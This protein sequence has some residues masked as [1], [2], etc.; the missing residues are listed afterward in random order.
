MALVGDTRLLLLLLVRDEQVV[1][2]ED[3]V[4]VLTLLLQR[5]VS[6]MEPNRPVVG[7][8]VALGNPGKMLSLLDDVVRHAEAPSRPG[9]REAA[10]AIEG[11]GRRRQEDAW[12]QGK[13]Q[14]CVV[15]ACLPP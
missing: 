13:E 10:R 11:V 12:A 15:C 2:R 3:D 5:G 4:G 7:E 14:E 8:A 1:V 9:A 6:R